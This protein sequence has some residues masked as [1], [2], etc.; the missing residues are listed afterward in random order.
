MRVLYHTFGCKTNQYDTERM[1]QEAEAR[2]AT[3]TSLRSEADVFVVN[4]CTVTNQADADARRLIRRL[5]RERPDARI[6]LAGSYKCGHCAYSATASC[7][8]MFETT[9]G[10]VYPMLASSTVKKLAKD[11]TADEFELIARVRKQGGI[12]YLEVTSYKGI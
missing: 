5:N 8:P 4:T 11:G 3:T 1:R 12:K 10:K 9:S 6:V 2:G 7:S